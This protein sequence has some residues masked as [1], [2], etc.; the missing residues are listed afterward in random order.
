MSTA[1]WTDFGGVLTP[2]VAN[3]VTRFCR[4]AR[5]EPAVFQQAMRAVAAR[6]GTTD[7]MAPLD[8]PLIGQHTWEQQMVAA[9]KAITG[10]IVDL[11]DFPRRWFADRA[12]NQ[13]WIA[14]LRAW[15]RAGRFVGLLSNMPPAWDEHWRRMV[16][17]D[18]LFDSVVLSF[19]A[20]CRKPEPAIFAL[21]AR[22][23]GQAPADC[24]LVDDLPANC[25]GARAA[26]W[27]AVCFTDA[28]D[29][30]TRIAELDTAVSPALTHI[31][32]SQS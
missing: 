17:A 14:Q 26:G 10:D 6:H 4:D 24:L 13:P 1:I 20:G 27:Q 2:P 16:P 3:T 29:A 21:A 8:T 18:E 22:L 15:R 12:V 19:Q 9:V 28:T 25:D 32:E 31:G 23:A 5:L 11:S 30:I 7:A